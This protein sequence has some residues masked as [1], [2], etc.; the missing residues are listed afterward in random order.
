MNDQARIAKYEAEL[1]RL[2]ELH[3]EL[4]V[5]WTKMPRYAWLAAFAPVV[6]YFKG[7]GWAVVELLVTAALVGTQAY[8][9]G[10]RR[11]ENRWTHQ[12]VAHDLANLRAEIAK[13]PDAG[14][15][16]GPGHD[17]RHAS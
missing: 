7:W 3:D 17:E 15:Q 5:L 9:I 16:P 13:R 8:L 4:D 12:S 11:S 2:D 1:Q 10:V 14:G 6:W